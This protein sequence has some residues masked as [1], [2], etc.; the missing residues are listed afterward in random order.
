[1]AIVIHDEPKTR[2]Y[3]LRRG[4][5]YGAA[6]GMVLGLAHAGLARLEGTQAVEV[7]RNWILAGACL[8]LLAGTVRAVFF[9]SN[10]DNNV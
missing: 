9:K 7:W 2:V 8:G 6:L 4:T 1:M 10:E 3:F 5:L